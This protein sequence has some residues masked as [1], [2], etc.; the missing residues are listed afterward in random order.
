LFASGCWST[1]L[2]VQLASSFCAFLVVSVVSPAAQ[3]SSGAFKCIVL[4]HLFLNSLW[5]P[6]CVCVRRCSTHLGVQLARMLA[7]FFVFSLLAEQLN[8]AVVLLTAYD[9]IV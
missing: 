2:G 6:V 8:A 1:Y 7:L 4:L 5:I 9:G 3:L